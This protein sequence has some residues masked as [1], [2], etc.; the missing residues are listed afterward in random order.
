MADERGAQKRAQKPIPD[1]LWENSPLDS[2][3][4]AALAIPD[5]EFDALIAEVD[6]LARTK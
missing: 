6:K 3:F 2:T 4:E 1:E 5:D